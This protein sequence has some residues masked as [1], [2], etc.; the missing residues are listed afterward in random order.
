[1]G[2]HH[3]PS[4]SHPRIALCF[5][6]QKKIYFQHNLPCWDDSCRATKVLVNL[7]YT[8]NLDGLANFLYTISRGGGPAWQYCVVNIFLVLFPLNLTSQKEGDQ[9]WENSAGLFGSKTIKINYL[10]EKVFQIREKN[11]ST[12]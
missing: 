8:R 11:V 4:L 10:H 7:D 5:A 1:M 12:F 6:E 2:N 9:N 3:P